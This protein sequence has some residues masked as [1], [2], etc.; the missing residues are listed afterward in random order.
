MKR[1]LTNNLSEKEKIELLSSLAGKKKY[2]TINEEVVIKLY[3]NI[4]NVKAEI[5][6]IESTAVSWINLTIAL[7]IFQILPLE[8]FEIKIFIFSCLPSLVILIYSTAF[9][10]LRSPSNSKPDFTVIEKADIDMRI[11]TSDAEIDALTEIHRYIHKLYN[12]KTFFKK[13][14]G[15]SV[16]VNFT[17]SILFIIMKTFIPLYLTSIV[18]ITIGILSIIWIF[19]LAKV[20]SFSKSITKE[21]PLNEKTFNP[22]QTF[23]ENKFQSIKIDDLKL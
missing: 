7:T 15:P 5:R 19:L 3:E 18:S 10:L 11:K 9:T 6:S 21:I 1:V 8:N 20:L 17:V 16:I 23:S 12:R 4:A 13:I 2:L 22:A 14:I